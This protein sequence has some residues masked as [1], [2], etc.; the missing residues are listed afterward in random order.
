[1][2]IGPDPASRFA[3]PLSADE[4]ESIVYH[5]LGPTDPVVGA[6]EVGLGMYNNVYRVDLRSGTRVAVRVA[7]PAAEQFRSEAQLMR[8]EHATT[9]WLT[10]ISNLTARVLATDWTGT[11]VERDWMISEWLPG[12]P[13]PDAWESL[14]THMR[15]DFF[16]QLGAVTRRIHDIPGPHFGT[17]HGPHFDRWSDAFLHSILAIVEDLRHS[18]CHYSDLEEIAELADARR[19]MLDR[20]DGARLLTGDLWTVNTLID[21]GPGPT[22][23]GIVDLDR[24]LWGDPLADWTIY[25]ALAKSGT[26]RD[27]FFDAAAYG[28]IPRDG[29]YS[30]RQMLYKAR[31][32][33]AVRLEGLRLANGETVRSSIDRMSEVFSSL[34]DG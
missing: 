25:M 32:I 15:Q 2:E 9:P 18:G 7:P 3:H 21:P 14:D 12:T 33:G 28:S 23:S 26:E 22:I 1:M 8:N 20:T 4:L 29:E 24:T 17:V 6:T 30:V 16:R 31:H 19:G 34:R 11:I 27:A 13:T 5:G 10:P